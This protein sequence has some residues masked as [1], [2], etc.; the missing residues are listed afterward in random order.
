VITDNVIGRIIFSLLDGIQ[1]KLSFAYCDQIWLGHKWSEHQMYFIFF[2]FTFFITHVPS[3]KSF[4]NPR[5]F[6]TTKWVLRRLF[7]WEKK[8]SNGHFDQEK[9][10]WSNQNIESFVSFSLANKIK[11]IAMPSI[12]FLM[13]TIFT[14]KDC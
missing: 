13:F 14:I 3:K 7:G 4:D 6:Y 9:D 2:G 5:E 1:L 12:T 8:I 10:Y 11:T